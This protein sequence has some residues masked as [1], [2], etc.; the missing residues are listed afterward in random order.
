SPYQQELHDVARKYVL[1]YSPEFTEGLGHRM[2]VTTAWHEE[3]GSLLSQAMDNL[4]FSS[5]EQ[6]VSQLLHYLKTVSGRLAL[7]ALE[8][9]TS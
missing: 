7:D 2:M 9:S 1:D 8:S 5:I 3:I 6:S 4:G